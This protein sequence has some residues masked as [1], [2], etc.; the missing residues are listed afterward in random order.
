MKTKPIFL[1]VIGGSLLISTAGCA[2]RLAFGTATKFG[3]DISQRADQR[4]DLSLGYDRYEI[5]SIPVPPKGSKEGMHADSSHDA[6][7]ILGTFNMDLDPSL[8]PSS[9]GLH[10]NQ[11]FATGMAARNAAA[12]SNIAAVLGEQAGKI[13]SNN[14]PIHA[15]AAAANR[16]TATNNQ[17]QPPNR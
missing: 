2:N 4:V 17:P 15:K 13:H 6:Y 1:L 11:L 9:G 5:A 14:A 16:K 7:S 8:L 3:L 12:D 10:L